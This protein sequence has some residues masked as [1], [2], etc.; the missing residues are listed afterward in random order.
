MRRHQGS[1][2][3]TKTTT[4][5]FLCSETKTQGKKSHLPEVVF[6]IRSLFIYIYIS[7]ICLFS[8]EMMF[9]RVSCDETKTPVQNAESHPRGYTCMNIYICI[10]VVIHICIYMRLYIY[11][12]IHILVNLYS[13]K[14][15][16]RGYIHMNIYIYICVYIYLYVSTYICVCIHTCIYVHIYIYI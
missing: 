13:A 4:L 9:L 8:C 2:N 6:N 11:E 12:Y 5:S 7:F 15:Y 16:P 10:I 1:G 3:P 14:S